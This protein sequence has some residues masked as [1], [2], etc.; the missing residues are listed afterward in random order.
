LRVFFDAEQRSA[1]IIEE[2]LG[3]G[4]VDEAQQE[5]GEGSGLWGGA[6]AGAD[7]A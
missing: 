2:T 3:D 1:F 4:V 7:G 5:V 6:A